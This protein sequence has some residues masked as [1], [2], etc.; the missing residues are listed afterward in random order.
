MGRFLEPTGETLGY[1]IQRLSQEANCAGCSDDVDVT[2][3][4]IC[5]LAAWQKSLPWSEFSRVLWLGNLE[6]CLRITIILDVCLNRQVKPRESPIERIRG[7]SLEVE[8]GR[9]HV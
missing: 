1:S 8:I 7:M 3:G 5:Y 6:I 4:P 2:H 9:A